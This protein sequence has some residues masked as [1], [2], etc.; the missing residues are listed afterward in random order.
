MDAALRPSHARSSKPSSGPR[1]ARMRT[2]SSSRAPCGRRASGRQLEQRS[3]AQRDRRR[4]RT[5]AGSALLKRARRGG[6]VT[7]TTASAD[8]STRGAS[9]ARSRRPSAADLPTRG[10]RLRTRT[11]SATARRGASERP[12]QAASSAA[13]RSRTSA[14]GRPEPVRGSEPEARRGERQ[15]RRAAGRAPAPS[16]RHQVA[17]LLDPR[18]ADP[19]NRVEILDRAERAVLSRQSRIFCAVTGPTPGRA[20]SCSIVALARLTFAVRRLRTAPPMTTRRRRR[21]PSRARRSASRPRPARRGSR[22][23]DRRGASR[24]R[25]ARRRRR[26]GC[27]RAGGRGLAPGRRRRRGRRPSPPVRASP[28]E[29]GRRGGLRRRGGTAV[30]EPSPREGEEREQHERERERVRPREA[31][32]VHASIV[33]AHAHVSAP[34][35]CRKTG[36]YAVRA[37]RTGFERGSAGRGHGSG[38]PLRPRHVRIDTGIR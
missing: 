11:A 19:G 3:L 26:R 37:N 15:R 17:E 18:R 33:L 28:L 34:D 12:S 35:V 10:R 31:D 4:A 9:S 1:G 24:R 22:P 27:R 2:W 7:R 14:G 25:P 30:G 23:R 13:A 32:G 6:P 5:S 21:C 20:S 36:R 8:V 16:R 29:R 38:R